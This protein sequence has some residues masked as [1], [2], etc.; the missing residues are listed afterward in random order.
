MAYIIA[1]RLMLA[2][3]YYWDLYEHQ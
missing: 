1:V 2:N 3:I